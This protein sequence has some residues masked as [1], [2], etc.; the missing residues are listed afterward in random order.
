MKQRLKE[1]FLLFDPRRSIWLLATGLILLLTLFLMFYYDHHP[2]L[3]DVEK[4]TQQ[5]A[6]ER[7]HTITTGY[8]T[9]ATLKEVTRRM[10]EKRGG[11]LSNDITPPSIFMDNV[12]SWE[13]GVLRQVR[14]L[15]QVLRFEMSRSQTQSVE[16]VD[17]MEAHPKFSIDSNSWIFP[18]SEAEYREGIEYLDNYLV[19]LVDAN[20]DDAQFYARADNLRDYLAIANQQLG[21]LASRLSQS[22]GDSRLNIDLDGDTAAIQSTPAPRETYMKTPWMEIDD[23][24]YEARGSCWALIHF[25]KAAEIDFALVLEKK[26]ATASMQQII[27]DLESTQATMWSPLV[28]NGRGFGLTANHSLVMASHISQAN[29]AMIE[30]RELLADG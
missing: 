4:H 18:R 6:M 28:L 8:T 2:D 5:S 9:V 10:L 3:F 23:V 27:R 25:L 16:D 15:A 20:E 24:F 22:I 21:S 29:A 7:G 17:L 30:L 11:Y 26:N 1:F 12:P 13:W 19:R 14:D